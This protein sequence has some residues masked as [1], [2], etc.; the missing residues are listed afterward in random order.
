MPVEIGIRELKHRTSGIVRVVREKR[1]E[2]VITLRGRP[3]ARLVPVADEE[4]SEQA[5]QELEEISQEVSVR[6]R[7]DRSAVELL[8]EMRR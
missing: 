5:L 4:D 7:S 3:V 1:A 8:T 2:Y 6:W